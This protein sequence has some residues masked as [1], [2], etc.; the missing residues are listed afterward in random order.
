MNKIADFV[1][2]SKCKEW[3]PKKVKV[4]KVDF[5]CVALDLDIPIKKK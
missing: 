1:N 4:V 5:A 3:P 2:I